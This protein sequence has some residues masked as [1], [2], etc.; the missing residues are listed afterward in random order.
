VRIGFLGGL[1][2]SLSDLG[3]NWA[4][5]HTHADTVAGLKDEIKRAGDELISKLPK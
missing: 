1:S 3:V 4:S 5:L 2:G